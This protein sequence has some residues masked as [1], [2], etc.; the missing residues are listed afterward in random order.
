VVVDWPRQRQLHAAFGEDVVGGVDEVEDLGHAYVRHCVVDDL[1]DLDGS[2]ADGQGCSQHDSVFPERLAGDHGCQLHHEPRPGVQVPVTQ[3][4][5]ERKVVEVL[6]QFGI[7]DL[8]G[9]DVARE[10]F[11]VILLCPFA[12]SH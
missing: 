11:V 6:D 8:Q 12:E 2:D 9:R 3:H 1:F 7:A 10:Q 4:L 5:V